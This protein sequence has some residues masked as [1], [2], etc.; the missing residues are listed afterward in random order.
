MIRI[1]RVI[2]RRK[3]TVVTVILSNALEPQKFTLFTLTIKPGTRVGLSLFLETGDRY[4]IAWSRKNL[5]GS[6]SH[7]G[8]NTLK[9]CDG[10]LITCE[11]SCRIP[12]GGGGI[13]I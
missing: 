9:K 7:W 2:W 6:D 8:K 1:T 10:L 3:L 5:I 13:S 11:K 12:M 4:G